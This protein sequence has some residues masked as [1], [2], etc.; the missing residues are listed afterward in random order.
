MNEQKYLA[1][2]ELFELGYLDEEYQPCLTVAAVKTTRE[3]CSLKGGPVGHAHV[4]GAAFALK[5]PREIDLSVAQV[6]EMSTDG[7]FVTQ[8]FDAGQESMEVESQTG[9]IHVEGEAPEEGPI[10]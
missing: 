5:V 9:A 8:P 6:S 7:T 4:P 3:R 2:N 10:K 1:V